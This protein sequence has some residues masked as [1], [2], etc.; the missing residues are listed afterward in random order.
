[1]IWLALYAGMTLASVSMAFEARRG[2]RWRIGDL[3]VAALALLGNFLF[4]NLTVAI[5]P[6]GASVLP[7]AI[8]DAACAVFFLY[9]WTRNGRWWALTLFGLFVMEC[10]EHAAPHASNLAYATFLNVV[11][12]LQLCTVVTPAFVAILQKRERLNRDEPGT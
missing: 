3:R 6:L 7:F 4:S 1:M 9:Q 5:L 10:A 12:T 2:A 8:A 11:Y